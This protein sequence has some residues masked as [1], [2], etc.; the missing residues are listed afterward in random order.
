MPNDLDAAASLFSL[1]FGSPLAETDAV[2]MPASFEGHAI[3]VEVDLKVRAEECSS[4]QS[5]AQLDPADRGTLI[6]IVQLESGDGPF[7][8]ADSLANGPDAGGRFISGFRR[9]GGALLKVFAR[10]FRGP[11]IMGGVAAPF[12]GD[13]FQNFR[14]VFKD[15]IT[16]NRSAAA[17]GGVVRAEQFVLPG[18]D[19]ASRHADG[20]SRAFAFT[21]QS[22]TG[23]IDIFHAQIFL[24]AL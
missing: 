22:P 23:T 21:C 10:Q 14:G 18:A 8:R 4:R 16:V 15:F 11:A 5:V 3:I 6:S 24:A 20:S 1:A 9:T 7:A 19:K 17:H 13:R 2:A 12:T